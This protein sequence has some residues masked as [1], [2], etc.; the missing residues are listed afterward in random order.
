LELL[1]AKGIEEN[2]FVSILA[3][4]RRQQENHFFR[5]GNKNI[6]WA[7]GD[8]HVAICIFKKLCKNP[9]CCICI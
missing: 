8:A 4:T 5:I 6:Q 9:T 1:V 2:A 3:T 7:N